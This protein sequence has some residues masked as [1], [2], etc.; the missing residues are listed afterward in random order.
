MYQ[1]SCSLEMSVSWHISLHCH[2]TGVN[3]LKRFSQ[4][5]NAGRRIFLHFCDHIPVAV[6]LWFHNNDILQAACVM[7]LSKMVAFRGTVILLCTKV[8]TVNA[9]PLFVIYCSISQTLKNNYI[10]S[11]EPEG[12]I[13]TN[14]LRVAHISNFKSPSNPQLEGF[15]LELKK[16]ITEI[17]VHA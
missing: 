13:E 5:Y 14:T 9:F 10:H 15:V 8:H 16:G 7:V 11:C 17:V 6:K 4:M 1:L 2:F 12:F 3:D